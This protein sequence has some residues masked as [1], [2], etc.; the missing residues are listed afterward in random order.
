MEISLK[1]SK[2]GSPQMSNSRYF[3]TSQEMSGDKDVVALAK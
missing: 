2:P 3:G 1:T